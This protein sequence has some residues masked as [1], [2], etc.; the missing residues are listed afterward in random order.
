MSLRTCKSKARK[1][2]KKKWA[3][4]PLDPAE[5]P[6]PACVVRAALSNRRGLAERKRP[7][8]T[9]DYSSEGRHQQGDVRAGAS[10]S[11]RSVR[12]SGRP[13]TAG[14]ATAGTRALV[15]LRPRFPGWS[16]G[17][18][19]RAERRHQR[20]DLSLRHVAVSIAVASG[21]AVLTR[22]GPTT[23]AARLAAEAVAERTRTAGA[24]RRAGRGTPR[25]PRG[26]PGPPWPNDPV[27]IIGSIGRG[28]CGRRFSD[29][30]GPRLADALVSTRRARCTSA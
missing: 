5:P 2:G 11:D 14:L 7:R 10:E 15:E 3:R 18:R 16:P 22:T 27:G 26:P 4:S 23:L 19:E 24:P 12:S 9:A 28:A 8:A 13:T 6:A 17:G 25:A 1:I 29:G 21:G 30:S 20:I